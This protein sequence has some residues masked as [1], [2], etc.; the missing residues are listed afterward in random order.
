MRIDPR[1]SA[2]LAVPVGLLAFVASCQLAPGATGRLPPYLTGSWGTAE[3]LYA[4]DTGQTQMHLSADGMGI[5]I[6]STLPPRR[7]DGADMG[8]RLPRI[9][10]GFPVRVTI[11]HT[12]LT[13]NVLAL[14]PNDAREAEDATFSCSVNP[15]GSTLTCAMPTGGTTVMKRGGDT[16]PVEFADMLAKVRA[17]LPPAAGR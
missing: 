11:S 12:T 5:L 8:E 16:M 10:M 4:G 1:K 3:S 14:D 17:A 7:I 15:A 2:R 6:G 13:V 9:I